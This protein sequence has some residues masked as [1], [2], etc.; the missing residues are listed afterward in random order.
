MGKTRAIY[1]WICFNIEYDAE[2]LFSGN[3]PEGTAEVFFNKRKAVCAGYSDLFTHL[4][5]KLKLF[6]VYLTGY[7]KSY[8]YVPGMKLTQSDHALVGVQIDR[9]WYLMEPTWGA[10]YLDDNKKFAAQ[11]DSSWFAPDPRLFILNHLPEDSQWQLLQ[12]PITLADYENMK[13]YP[14]GDLKNLIRGEFSTE[15]ILQIIELPNLPQ[16]FG[17][18]CYQLKEKGFTYIEIMKILQNEHASSEFFWD[19]EALKENGFTF[20]DILTLLTNKDK[21][22]NHRYL[23]GLLKE[24]GFTAQDILKFFS[25]APFPENFFYD[26]CDLKEEGFSQD[27]II[28]LLRHK[29]RQEYYCQ[30]YRSLKNKGFS[31]EDILNFIEISP[32]PSNFFFDCIK[33][34]GN[35]LSGKD[36]VEL[37][38][39]TPYPERYLIRCMKLREYGFSI[40]NVL[41]FAKSREMPECYDIEGLELPTFKKSPRPP[42]VSGQNLYFEIEAKG[43]N[44]VALSMNGKQSHLIKQETIF[45]GSVT[46]EPGELLVLI[47]NPSVGANSY[48]YV[49]RFQ[50]K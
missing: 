39:T 25:A 12:K 9:D 23:I 4:A 21:P 13:Y 32:L 26:V 28:T 45:M 48:S 15:E 36:I 14:S 31:T 42:L 11:Y 44:R 18:Y 47:L 3:L 20:D 33:L 22:Q 30:H 10:G 49:I 17:Q 2:G 19:C 16:C 27:E 24:K 29:N 50:I 6:S 40:E 1:A 35:G 7:S 34:K 38:K 37:L 5:E 8:G 41:A 46:S 43:T